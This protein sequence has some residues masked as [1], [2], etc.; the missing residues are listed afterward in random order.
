MIKDNNLQSLEF[1]ICNATIE[2]MDFIFDLAT[3]EGWN[4]GL[5]DGKTVYYAD[6]KGF[7]IGKLGNKPIGCVSGVTYGDTFGFLGLYIVIPEYRHKGYGIRLWNAAMQHLGDRNIALDGVIEQQGNYKKSGFQF[8][9]RNIRY[10]YI[11]KGVQSSKAISLKDLPISQISDYDRKFFPEE[12]KI[13]L[14]QWVNMPNAVG[15]GI[16]KENKLEGMGMI[17]KC[18]NGYKIGPLYAENDDIAEELFSSLC[19]HAS[20]QPIFID[21]PEF[22]SNAMSWINKKRV[23][24]VFETSRMYTKKAPSLFID[25]IYGVTTLEIG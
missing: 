2:E 1:Q 6:P 4:P 5:F 20:E 24:K 19:S 7:F 22:N 16:T 8:A 14:Q 3:K 23:N 13:F 25:G 15:Y 17:R 11:G 9:Y 10:E 21:V 12:R 18:V